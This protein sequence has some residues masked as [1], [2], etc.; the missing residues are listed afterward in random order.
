MPA[1]TETASETATRP[2]K[3]KP[4]TSPAPARPSVLVWNTHRG[5]RQAVHSE[6]AGNDPSGQPRHNLTTVKLLPGLNL[7]PGEE[8]AKVASGLATM[9]GITVLSDGL[10]SLPLA[11]VKQAIA[12]TGQDSVLQTL[13][14]RAKS[15]PVLEV[16]TGQIAKLARE[17][18]SG[19]QARNIQ[20]SHSRRV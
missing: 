13:A 5:V 16:I 15:E 6:P 14:T 8:A 2:S 17:G 10:D 1:E 4:P 7:V 12:G 19:T 3:G 20:L 18:H 9:D 11:I